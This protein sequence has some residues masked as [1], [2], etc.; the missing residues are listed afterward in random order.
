MQSQA[1]DIVIFPNTPVQ[2]NTF[3]VL[4]CVLFVINNAKKTSLQNK[5]NL[6]IFYIDKVLLIKV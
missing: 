3:L 6:R 2:D 1:D 5:A 4:F